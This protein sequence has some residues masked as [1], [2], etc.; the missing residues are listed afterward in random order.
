M[1]TKMQDSCSNQQTKGSRPPADRN[2]GL[3]TQGHG[4]QS[5]KI[6]IL[7]E[8]TT[9]PDSWALLLLERHR[10]KFAVTYVCMYV[11]LTRKA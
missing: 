9:P 11:L 7:L 5:C 10:T 8:A 4:S 2:S 3:Q 6:F 1:L